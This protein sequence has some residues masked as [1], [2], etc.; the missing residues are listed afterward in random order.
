MNP[1]QSLETWLADTVPL[2]LEDGEYLP[3]VEMTDGRLTCASSTTLDR[4][5]A[6]NWARGKANE[7]GHTKTVRAAYVAAR[8]GE[9]IHLYEVAH[10]DEPSGLWLDDRACYDQPVRRA[11]PAAIYQPTPPLRFSPLAERAAA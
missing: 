3:A 6:Q 10:L 5:R 9:Q 2:R 8:Q 1:A 4:D 7:L 11:H